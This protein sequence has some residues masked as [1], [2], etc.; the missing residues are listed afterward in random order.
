MNLDTIDEGVDLA[1]ITNHLSALTPEDPWISIWISKRFFW[2]CKRFEL[3]PWPKKFY[4]WEGNIL[5]SFNSWNSTIENV[6]RISHISHN[7][8]SNFDERIKTILTSKRFAQRKA[9]LVH[10][11]LYKS[12]TIN[13]KL[14]NC[15][16]SKIIS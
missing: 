4:F 11:L 13:S 16:R 10:N 1:F 8:P 12:C 2:T 9:C 3:K 14:R 15:N 5:W 6:A 7:L